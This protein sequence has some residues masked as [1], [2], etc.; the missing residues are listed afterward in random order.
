MIGVIGR[1]SEELIAHPGIAGVDG[2]IRGADNTG[3]RVRD[4]QIGG[5]NSRNRVCLLL[6]EDYLQRIIAGT[7][8][9][10]QEKALPQQRVETGECGS[11]I[12]SQAVIGCRVRVEE[13]ISRVEA[14]A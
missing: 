8:N 4:L 1:R 2:R 6:T 14:V 5:Q 7:S 11:R 13:D 10:K 9:R 3:K 12:R